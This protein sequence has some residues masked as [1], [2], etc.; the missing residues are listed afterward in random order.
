MTRRLAPRVALGTLVASCALL[1]PGA[2]YAN[3]DRVEIVNFASN[4]KLRADV[5]GASVQDGQ[6]VFL[7]PN[8]SSASQ[9][10]D[11]STWGWVF[12]DPR[13]ALG[14][15]P[16]GRPDSGQRREWT[17]DRAIPLYSGHVQDSSVDLPGHERPL[18]GYR[19]G[20]CPERDAAPSAVRRH[21][22]ARDQEPVAHDEVPGH[23][24]PVRNEASPAGGLAVVDLYLVPQGMECRQPDL[25]ARRFSNRA[26]YQS[27][28]IRGRREQDPGG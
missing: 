15:V 22:P 17:A 21:G 27:A 10:F 16:D 26:D 20:T 19:R 5:M 3:T 7:W 13:E 28:S 25:E 2:A 12:P 1:V 11:S 6:G 18:L 14:Q 8:N 23:R 24:E 9:E 4:G